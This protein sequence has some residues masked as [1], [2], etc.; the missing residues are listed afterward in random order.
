MDMSSFVCEPV[1][2]I[3]VSHRI[4]LLNLQLVMLVMYIYSGGTKVTVTGR[5]LDSAAEPRINLTVIVTRVV[6]KN[7]VTSP[8]SSKFGVLLLNLNILKGLYCIVFI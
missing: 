8:A 5:N 2:P 6:N 4:G 7:V 1:G 3:S